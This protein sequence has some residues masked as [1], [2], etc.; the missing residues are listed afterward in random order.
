MFVQKQVR[1]KYDK[2]AFSV[3][4]DTTTIL[5]N[6]PITQIAS[7]P[8]YLLLLLIERVYDFDLPT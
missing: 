5:D 4:Q 7:T 3:A 1:D 2:I 6:N 8:T